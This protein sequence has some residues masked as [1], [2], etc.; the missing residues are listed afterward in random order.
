VVAEMPR[1]GATTLRIVRTLRSLPDPAAS[2]SL[3]WR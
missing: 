1:A 2:Y 3:I